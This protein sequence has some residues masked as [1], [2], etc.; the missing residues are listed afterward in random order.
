[1][2]F[3]NKNKYKSTAIE[4]FQYFKINQAITEG[5]LPKDFPNDLKDGL[6]SHDI[7]KVIVGLRKRRHPNIQVYNDV[8]FVN[9]MLLSK[10]MEPKEF[11]FS[12]IILE[13]GSADPLSSEESDK[14]IAEV[15]KAVDEV[16]K[17]V[18]G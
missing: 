3:W 11:C 10:K 17:E 9:E 16:Y 14:L 2:L 7:Q 13:N 15:N 12:L 6:I 4:G 18:F 5:E 1:M 8:D